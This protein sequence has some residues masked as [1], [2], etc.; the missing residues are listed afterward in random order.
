MLRHEVKSSECVDGSDQFLDLDHLK[1][2][3]LNL[4]KNGNNRWATIASKI[5]NRFKK[6]TTLY[7][8]NLHDYGVDV[9]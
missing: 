9:C 5:V 6:T 7:W 8:I 3:S 4:S 1:S 2:K